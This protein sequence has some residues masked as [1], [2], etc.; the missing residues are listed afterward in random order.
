MRSHVRQVSFSLPVL[1]TFLLVN[2]FGCDSIRTVVFMTKEEE[3][4][5]DRR[6]KGER[7]RW[8]EGMSDRYKGEEGKKK[9]PDGRKNGNRNGNKEGVKRTGL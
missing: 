4:E 9:R 2:K 5:V 8:E 1:Y 6:K 3:E 7:E